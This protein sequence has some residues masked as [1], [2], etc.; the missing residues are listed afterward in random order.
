MTP[1]EKRHNL[2]E[3]IRELLSAKEVDTKELKKLTYRYHAVDAQIKG[4]AKD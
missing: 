3:K 2:A 4:A 1:K